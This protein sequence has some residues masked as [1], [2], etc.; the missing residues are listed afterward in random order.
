MFFFSSMTQIA[1]PIYWYFT[2][3]YVKQ[4]NL[5]ALSLTFID[6]MSTRDIYKSLKV[7]QKNDKENAKSCV[8]IVNC[9]NIVKFD[10]GYRFILLGFRFEKRFENIP[11]KI[12]KGFEF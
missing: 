6:R 2:Y 9:R 11:A 8:F 1:V 3:A 10:T 12:F 4:K 5:I 7:L